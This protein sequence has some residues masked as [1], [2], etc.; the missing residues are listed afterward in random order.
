MSKVRHHLQKIRM[1]SMRQ[2]SL[3][4]TLLSLA[5]VCSAADKIQWFQSHSNQPITLNAYL[6]MTSKCSYCK[7]ADAFLENF[8]KTHAWLKVHRYVIDFG[9]PS[10]LKNRAPLLQREHDFQNIDLRS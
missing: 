2:L 6:F 1:L 9:P 7:Q 5:F 10:I 3:M 8:A 4:I